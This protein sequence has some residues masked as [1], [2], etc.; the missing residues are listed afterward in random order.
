MR[1]FSSCGVISTKRIQC[2]A[3]DS[4]IAETPQEHSEEEA[5]RHPAES[6]V[7]G[8]E[9]NS[10]IKGQ[11]LFNEKAQACNSQL[12]ISFFSSRSTSW[13]IIVAKTAMT[14]SDSMTSV[15]LNTWNP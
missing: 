8:T 9:I 7:P 6:E 12:L 13:Y 1:K 10:P 11:E 5:Q 3:G 14:R 4:G 2:P 15:K